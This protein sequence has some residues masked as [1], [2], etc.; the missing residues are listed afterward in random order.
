MFLKWGVGGGGE[1][2]DEDTFPKVKTMVIR[3]QHKPLGERN[4]SIS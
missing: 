1:E 3:V 4:N 2:V